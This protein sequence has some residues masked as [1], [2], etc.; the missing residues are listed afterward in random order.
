MHCGLQHRPHGQTGLGGMFSVNYQPVEA[1]TTEDFDDRGVRQGYLSS[2]TRLFSLQFRFQSSSFSS[3]VI[4]GLLAQGVPRAKLPTLNVFHILKQIPII[5][6]SYHSYARIPLSSVDEKSLRVTAC[7]SCLASALPIDE[8][9][10]AVRFVVFPP[11]P[12]P[13]VAD[14]DDL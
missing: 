10:L 12:N 14:V 13:P 7:A 11:A 1:S 5:G 9:V 3:S 8:P 4:N 2:Q 6:I